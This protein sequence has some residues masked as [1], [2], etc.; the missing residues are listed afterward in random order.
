MKLSELIAKAQEALETHGDMEVVDDN[1]EWGLTSLTGNMAVVG[2]E[3]TGRYPREFQRC[4]DFNRKHVFVIN[5]G[6]ED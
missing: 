1:Q 4:D 2:V 5:S 3:D 6:E